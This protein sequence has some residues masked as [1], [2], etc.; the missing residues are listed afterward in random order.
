MKEILWW[1]KIQS[2]NFKGK[3]FSFPNPVPKFPDY[4]NL[5][6]LKVKEHNY[7]LHY[8]CKAFSA[9]L[10]TLYQA[11]YSWEQQGTLGIGQ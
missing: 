4:Q 1:N 7:T 3:N 6:Y 8:L 5:A 10:F 11:K 9:L 2:Y